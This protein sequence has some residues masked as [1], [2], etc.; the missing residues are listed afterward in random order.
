MKSKKNGFSKIERI[1][2]IGI[3]LAILRRCVPVNQRAQQHLNR[4]IAIRVVQVGK[5]VSIVVL[6][7]RT[8]VLVLIT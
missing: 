1:M 7:V 4:C 3:A 6:A 2:L 5:P 8:G